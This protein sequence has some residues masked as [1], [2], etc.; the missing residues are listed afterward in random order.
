MQF[1]DRL[2]ELRVGP[3]ELVDSLPAHTDEL[4]NLGDAHEG[5]H[6]GHIEILR[7]LCDNLWHRLVN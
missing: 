1:G 6:L 3:R 2:R 5:W 4:C 7:L